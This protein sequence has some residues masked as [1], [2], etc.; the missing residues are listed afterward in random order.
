[1]TTGCEP[2][3]KWRRTPSLSDVRGPEG[4]GRERIG[5][6]G[7]NEMCA[8]ATSMHVLT[9]GPPRPRPAHPTATRRASRSE[10]SS[11]RV[12]RI[13]F[14]MRLRSQITEALLL[15]ALKRPRD[16]ESLG[17]LLPRRIEWLTSPRPER[18]RKAGVCVAFC[19]GER[20]TRDLK[21]SFFGIVSPAR[22][23]LF[24][25]AGSLKIGTS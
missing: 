7:R 22:R 5:P 9:L 1:M 14:V 10:R 23:P 17:E 21:R 15:A 12:K 25:P 6:A 20:S 8:L 3:S 24:D 18:I 16:L 2:A 4:P 13:N 19:V 11:R